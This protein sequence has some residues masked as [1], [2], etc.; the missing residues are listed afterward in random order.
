MFNT[1]NYLH[2]CSAR[3][4]N[5]ISSGLAKQAGDPA[6]L[7]ELGDAIVMKGVTNAVD[8]GRETSHVWRGG[9]Q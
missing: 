1:V 6:A 3:P 4:Y 2:T 8:L 7:V 9:V 5:T